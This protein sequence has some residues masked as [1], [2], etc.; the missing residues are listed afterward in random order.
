MMDWKYAVN[1]KRIYIYNQPVSIWC[2]FVT[3]S[4]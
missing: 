4:L 2:Y 1:K 3:N